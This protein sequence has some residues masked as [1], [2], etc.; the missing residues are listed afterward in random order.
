MSGTTEELSRLEDTSSGAMF[1]MSKSTSGDTAVTLGDILVDTVG[2]EDE[3]KNSD[4][5]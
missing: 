4:E 1:V 3:I 5:F 2:I